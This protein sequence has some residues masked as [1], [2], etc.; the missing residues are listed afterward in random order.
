MAYFFPA[1][2]AEQT[3]YFRRSMQ[4]VNEGG[5]WSGAYLEDVISALLA[6]EVAATRDRTPATEVGAFR[7]EAA[8]ALTPLAARVRDYVDMTADEADHAGDDTSRLPGMPSS[9][10]WWWHPGAPPAEAVV[11]NALQMTEDRL[12][13]V[14]EGNGVHAMLAS[15]R[16]QLVFM[17]DTIAR[18]RPPT[19]AEKNSL[20]LHVIA[21]REYEADDPI[22]CDALSGAAY[23]FKNV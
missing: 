15:V 10:W 18:G 7:H 8:E 11:E 5:C 9:H 14:P 6:V 1:P 13:R 20:T 16:T 19:T 2:F 4:G 21:V 22:Y 3:A 23:A 12:G 17:R